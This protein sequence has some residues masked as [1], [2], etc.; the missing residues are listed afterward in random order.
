MKV[1]IYQTSNDN[2]SFVNDTLLKIQ[3]LP[4]FVIPQH[5][6]VTPA[7]D[8]KIHKAEIQSEHL[9]R[10]SMQTNN[11]AAWGFDRIFFGWVHLMEVVVFFHFR[12]YAICVCLYMHLQ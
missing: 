1:K 7:D 4:P 11:L 5:L 8:A 3:Q 10:E 6:S 12:L 2:I 9:P